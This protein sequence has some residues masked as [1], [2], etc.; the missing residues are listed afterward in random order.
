MC[1]EEEKYFFEF[2]KKL[3]FPYFGKTCKLHRI[4]TCGGAFRS[5]R[6]AECIPTS[7]KGAKCYFDIQKWENAI[8]WSTYSIVTYGGAFRSARQA[9]RIPGKKIFLK[10]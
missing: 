9:E 6:Q 3:L 5:A 7:K 1:P 4:L 10:S 2:L 8:I